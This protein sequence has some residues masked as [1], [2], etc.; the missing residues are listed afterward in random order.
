M[1]NFYT[2]I[3]L[4]ERQFEVILVSNDKDEKGFQKH[5]GGMPWCA[6]PYGDPRIK[7]FARRYNVLGVPMLVILDTVTGFKI[8]DTARKDLSLAQQAEYGVKGVWKSWAKL[9]EI[10]KVRGVKAAAEDARAQAEQEHRYEIER[11][12]NKRARLQME[13]EAIGG[14]LA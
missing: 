6:I 1:R 4:P 13:G 2:D 14:D 5:F 8:T 11:R 10:N 12:K 3:N 9:H 7:E